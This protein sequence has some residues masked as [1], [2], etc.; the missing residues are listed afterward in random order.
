[1]LL[2]DADD[3]VQRGGTGAT[4]DW[5]GRGGWPRRRRMLLAGGMTPENVRD[6]VTAVRPFGIDVSSGVEDAPGIKDPNASGI[7]RGASR[8]SRS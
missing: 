8:V 7:V 5:S 4:A 6:A 3:P 2:V 1:M